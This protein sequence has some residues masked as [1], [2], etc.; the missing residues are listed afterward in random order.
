MELAKYNDITSCAGGPVLHVRV[1]P[2]TI[3]SRLMR[4]D[5]CPGEFYSI[6]GLGRHRHGM[7]HGFSNPRAG[8]FTHVPMTA[9]HFEHDF[10][11]VRIQTDLFKKHFSLPIDYSSILQWVHSKGKTDKARDRGGRRID[12]GNGGLC[13]LRKDPL[14][15]EPTPP[16]KVVGMQQLPDGQ[17]H[18]KHQLGRLLDSMQNCLDDLCRMRGK[19]L[20]FSNA[21]RVAMH[22]RHLREELGARCFRFEW[23]TIQLK[24]L[25]DLEEVVEHADEFNCSWPGCDRTSAYCVVLK[26]SDGGVWSL[27]VLANTRKVV[28]EYIR[29]KLL[30]PTN[31]AVPLFHVVQQAKV[32]LRN[33]QDSYDRLVQAHRGPWLGHEL[34]WMHPQH[35]YLNDDL[36][37]TET[38]PG[39]SWF[40]GRYVTTSAAISRDFWLSAG[41]HWAN[42]WV[43]DPDKTRT[44]V[45]SL[46]WMC[47]YQVS[48]FKFWECMP[49]IESAWDLEG[50]VKQKCGA[51]F[52]GPHPR[53]SPPS[54]AGLADL[55]GEDIELKRNQ[56]VAVLLD[57][58]TWVE[59]NGDTCTSLDLRSALK[60]A[61]TKLR[62]IKVELDEF[63]LTMFVQIVVLSGL[64][65]TGAN[66]LTQSYPVEQ[67]GSY[68]TL[69]ES[70]VRPC[71]IDLALHQ[72]SAELGLERHRGDF[73]E[74]ICCESRPSRQMVVDVFFCGMDLFHLMWDNKSCRFRSF[75]K[76][77]GRHEWQPV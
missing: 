10:Y 56:V 11:V 41:V 20:C 2:D 63:R 47:S 61:N 57:L 69:V 48:W 55:F 43:R 39:C 27:K 7:T 67:R 19:P 65:K 40:T 42:K 73:S 30:H 25:S 44:D 16:R 12:F 77:H 36:S 50:V 31:G 60:N 4:F 15:I 18:I 23:V 62:P 45:V 46:C 37:Y 14:G 52:G 49:A 66:V 17:P 70:G 24:K 35:L 33:L 71:D 54:F 13:Y 53:F 32:Y 72:L 1:D 58:V 5:V 68:K 3:S 8:S 22:A 29:K 9:C 28:G 76:R 59:A 6:E 21:A 74:C 51:F 75:V 64:V 34:K 38:L 26:G